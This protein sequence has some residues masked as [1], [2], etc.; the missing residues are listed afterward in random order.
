MKTLKLLTILLVITL[1]AASV[2]A[3]E[4]QVSNP[5]DKLYAMDATRF[6]LGSLKQFNSLVFSFNDFKGFFTEKDARILNLGLNAFLDSK[7]RETLLLNAL[8]SN[9]AVKLD[10]SIPE[11]RS[12]LD[13]T[14]K[15]IP[16]TLKITPLLDGPNA[17]QITIVNGSHELV[18]DVDWAGQVVGF[19]K[20]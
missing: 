12:H 13:V 11:R 10:F 18:Y 7:D 5:S 19:S 1:G 8:R 9:Q 4:L 2:Q 15:Q 6:H 20:K 3:A 17:F 16:V 14:S